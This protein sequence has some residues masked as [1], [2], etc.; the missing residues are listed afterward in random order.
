MLATATTSGSQANDG[1]CAKLRI[2]V[3]GGNVFHGS[4]TLTGTTYDE[5]AGNRCWSK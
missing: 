1:N 4:T 2:K 3:D 5:T